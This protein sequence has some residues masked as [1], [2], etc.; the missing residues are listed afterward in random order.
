[1]D[2][3]SLS[4]IVELAQKSENLSTI[5]AALQAGGLV[6]TLSLSGP[7]TVFA[8]TNEAFA[9]LGA[10]V[11]ELLKPENKAKLVEILKYHVV[12]GATMAADLKDGQTVETLQGTEVTVRLS[13]K[14]AMI[15]ESTV[16]TADVAA[17]N[18]VVHIVDNVLMPKM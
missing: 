18:G 16:T 7:Y 12:G 10:T 15:N 14:G 4:T 9:K 3:S 2:K 5:V 17:S 1:M 6:E 13:E 11:D 8:P